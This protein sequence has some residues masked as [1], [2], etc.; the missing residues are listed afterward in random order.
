M[1]VI[2]H[3]PIDPSI[4]TLKELHLLK[5]KVKREIE[6]ELYNQLRTHEN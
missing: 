1:K 3:E 2:F 4:Y 6:N 5:A